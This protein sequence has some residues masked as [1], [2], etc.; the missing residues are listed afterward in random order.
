MFFLQLSWSARRW[1]RATSST[2]LVTLLVDTGIRPTVDATYPLAEARSAFERLA[3]G[4]VFGK[5]VL[6]HA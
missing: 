4:D 1:A 6:T 2:A 3:A 5:L